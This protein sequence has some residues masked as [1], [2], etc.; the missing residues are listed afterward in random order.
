LKIFSKNLKFFIKF[1]NFNEIFEIFLK[2]I[3][4]NFAKHLKTLLKFSEFLKKIW[5]FHGIFESFYKTFENYDEILKTF[6]KNFD[7]ILKF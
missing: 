5:N 4:K 1:R 7:E 6:M 2:I 3:K